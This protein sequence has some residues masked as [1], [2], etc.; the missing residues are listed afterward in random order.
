MFWGGKN[1]G[2]NTPCD[3]TPTTGQPALDASPHH[4]L[5]CCTHPHSPSPLPEPNCSATAVCHCFLDT[6][7]AHSFQIH[8]KCTFLLGILADPSDQM[9]CLLPPNPQSP[10]LAFS[11]ALILRLSPHSS[12][13]RDS[14]CQTVFLLECS[15]Y[16]STVSYTWSALHKCSENGIA[17]QCPHQEH[18]PL[19][20]PQDYSI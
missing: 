1:L 9:G 15:A 19:G 12:S 20:L 2:L 11:Y 3:S 18:N 6:G 14:K 16:Q 7:S 5:G 10:W 13:A 17:A 8:C 4:G